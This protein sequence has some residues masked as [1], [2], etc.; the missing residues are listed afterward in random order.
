MAYVTIITSARIVFTGPVELRRLAS[1]KPTLFQ[2]FPYEQCTVGLHSYYNIII[3]KLQVTNQMITACKAY[4]TDGGCETVWSQETKD[5]IR[6]LNDCIRL[7]DEYQACFHKT[8]ALLQE[9]PDERQFEF[10]EMYIFG[11]FD[12]FKRRLQKI[13]EMFDTME[14]YSHLT[15]SKIEG[16][17]LLLELSR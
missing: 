6:K 12:T 7:N 8:K 11:K 5:V 10:S 4:I 3:I 15:D 16:K 13:I 17:Q 1:I 9:M 14:V 2:Y